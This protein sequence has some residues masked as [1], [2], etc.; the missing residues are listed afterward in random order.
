[1]K[2]GN[3]RVGEDDKAKVWENLCFELLDCCLPG[4]H[5]SLLQCAGVGRVYFNILLYFITVVFWQF[6]K[7]ERL[8]VAS[9]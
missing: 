7:C 9:L 3:G 1:M 6:I 5:T 8:I 4:N 2:I